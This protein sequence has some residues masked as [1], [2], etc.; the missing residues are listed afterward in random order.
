[1]DEQIGGREPV[2]HALGEAL[3][4]DARLS[5]EAVP[6]GRPQPL[7]PPAESDH[8]RSI[9]PQRL[10]CRALQIAHGPTASGHEH[11]RPVR[12][13]AELAPRLASLPGLVEPLVREAA[14]AGDLARR[15][16][17]AHLLL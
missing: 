5:G 14:D 1:V 10:L 12:R 8:R 11:H 3:H 6:K 17:L 15:G 2:R 16:D 7:V 4:H 13:E 9:E